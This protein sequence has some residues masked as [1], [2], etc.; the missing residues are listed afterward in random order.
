LTTHG[1]NPESSAH[2]G[3]SALFYHI[4][5]HFHL[6]MRS[7]EVPLSNITVLLKDVIDATITMRR[8]AAGQKIIAADANT[9]LAEPLNYS[10]NGGKIEAHIIAADT[11]TRLAADKRVIEA[12]TE[13]NNTIKALKIFNRKN[14]EA[15]K[16]NKQNAMNDRELSNTFTTKTAQG[17][18]KTARTTLM[19]MATLVAT[20]NAVHV[21]KQIML[22]SILSIKSLRR[23]SV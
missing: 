18:L 12:Q 1:D 7:S 13:A 4:F 5:E 15:I 19:P 21:M 23:H 3:C 20:T 14:N 16:N 9:K 2:V 17:H 10:Q 8:L 22:R 6:C 11:N